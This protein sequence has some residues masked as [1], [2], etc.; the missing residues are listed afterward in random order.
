MIS[1]CPAPGLASYAATKAA[2]RYWAEALHY[3]MCD[4]VDVMSWDC[5]SVITKLNTFKLGFKTN[6]KTA[7]KG[8]FKDIGR[9]RRS[10]GCW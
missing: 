4:K 7:V 3:E 10:F 6:V 5:G 1:H 8:C 2:V 9:D